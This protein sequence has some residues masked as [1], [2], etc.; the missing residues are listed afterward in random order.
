MKRV[1]PDIKLI[2]SAVSNW[3]DGPLSPMDLNNKTEWVERT[4]LMLEQAGDRIDYMALH[5]Y[6]DSSEDDTFENNMAFGEDFNERILRYEGLI[7]AVSLERGIK[8]TISIAVD[9]WAPAHHPR[10][11]R[12][13]AIIN[14]IRDEF[15]IMRLPTKEE[16]FHRFRGGMALNLKDALVTAQYLNIFIRHAY[17]IRIANFVP[18]PT[19]MGINSLL[20]RPEGPV[21]LETIFYPFELYNHTCGQLALD[22][23]WSGDTFSGAYRDRAYNGIRTLD[24]AATLDN[25]R[26]QLVV[27]VVNQSKDKAMETTVSLVSGEFKGNARASVIN[28]P[29]IKAGNT[30]ENPN[31]VEIKEA[32]FKAS[33]K[34]FT[35]TFEPHSVTALVC[36]VN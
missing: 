11:S 6:A 17:S 18:M 14:V 7:H 12:R 19:F 3:E 9:E 23:F 29:D 24:V 4:Q 10:F 16:N 2:A 34:A 36:A 15:G 20:S 31:Q 5:R 22:A 28:G 32:N 33:G 13:N 35:F 27:F 26:K 25:E 21:L 30:E 8:H 1:D